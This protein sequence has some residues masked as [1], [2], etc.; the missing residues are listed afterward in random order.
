MVGSALGFGPTWFFRKRQY[1]EVEN[2]N[3]IRLKAQRL[4]NLPVCSVSWKVVQSCTCFLGCCFCCSLTF[5]NSSCR[6]WYCDCSSV[7]IVS[8]LCTVSLSWALSKSCECCRLLRRVACSLASRCNTHQ[9]KHPMK[10]NYIYEWNAKS[11]VYMSS[12][13]AINWIDIVWDKKTMLTYIGVAASEHINDYTYNSVI[14][15]NFKIIHRTICDTSRTCI[16]WQIV[17]YFVVISIQVD[18]FLNS[19]TPA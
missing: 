16:R 2:G 7:N 1:T 12:M 19:C 14:C 3:I 6:C 4:L 8:S 5:C 10:H 17:V 15:R 11:N 9:P 18:F 13:T